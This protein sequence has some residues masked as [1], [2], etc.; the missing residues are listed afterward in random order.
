MILDVLHTVY[1]TNYID[2]SEELILII[3]KIFEYD[4]KTND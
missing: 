3:L 2:E 1:D 4:I